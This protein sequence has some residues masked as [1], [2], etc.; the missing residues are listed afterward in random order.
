[1][2]LVPESCLTIPET[3]VENESVDTPPG[4]SSKQ[5]NTSSQMSTPSKILSML[6]CKKNDPGT[7]IE[8]NVNINLCSC[9]SSTSKNCLFPFLQKRDKNK[10][11]KRVTPQAQKMSYPHIGPNQLKKYKKK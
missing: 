7:V 1:M 3:I 9:T 8:Q 4:S 5:S 2:T 6:F 11:K 10:S